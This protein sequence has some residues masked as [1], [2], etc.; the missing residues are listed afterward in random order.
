MILVVD[1]GSTKTCWCAAE[2]GK[3]LVRTV[4]AGLNPLFIS[5]NDME[6]EIRKNVL[7]HFDMDDCSAVYFYGAG[8]LPEKLAPMQR[9]LRRCLN[10]EN[11]E[12]GSDMLGAARGLAGSEPAVVCIM[13]TGSN[14]CYYD[15]ERIVKSVSPL[16]YILG[17][18]GSGAVLGKLLL[19]DMLKNQFSQEFTEKFFCKYGFS[20]ADII[21]SVYRK[22]FP[23]RFLASFAP[24]LAEN[25]DNPQVWDLVKGSFVSFIRRNVLQ[26]DCS[27]VPVHFVGSV[28]YHF[29]WVMF[30]IICEM[31]F[32]PRLGRIFDT[33]M[34]GLLDFH[35]RN[36]GNRGMRL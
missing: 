36:D 9:L 28:A 5:E 20:Q 22:P 8:C 13:G 4:T 3:P 35:L 33:P 14:S 12:V 31:K 30:A 16:G 27:D 26:Y 34:P 17:D 23:N 19:G 10:V 24:F 11:V 15:G 18:E 6:E 21:E 29:R 2:N 32:F 25:L 1:A 7:A